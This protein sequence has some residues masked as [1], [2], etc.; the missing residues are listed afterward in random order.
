M[1]ERK[2]DIFIV[3]FVASILI[4]SL[5]PYQAL[6]QNENSEF[7]PGRYIIVLEDDISP[8]EVIVSKGK[9]PDFVFN[10]A[11]NGFA[12]SFSAKFLEDMEKDPRVKFIEKDQR[13]HAFL[14]TTP[15]GID[16]IDAEGQVSVENAEVVVAVLDT[17]IDDTHPDLNVIKKVNCAKGGPFGGNCVE[18]DGNDG[19]GHGTHVAGT[20]GAIQNDIGVEGVAPGVKIVAVKVLDNKG[21]GWTSWIIGGIDY[22]TSTRTN[23]DPN[24][25]IDV[26]NMSLG[27]GNSE[28]EKTAIQNS[29]AQGIVYVVAAGN[30]GIEA[31]NTSPANTPE[32][33]TVSALADS[34]GICGSQ[35]DPT[36]Y[37]PD[38]TFA[39][40]SNFGSFVDIAAPGTDIYSTLPGGY[41]FSSGTSMASPHVAGAVALYIIDNGKPTNA[42]GVETLRNQLVS[43][44]ISQTENCLDETGY[45]GFSGDLDNF[46]EPLLYVGL[47]DQDGD[48]VLDPN[49]NCPTIANTNQADNYGTT[50]GDACEDTD[51][52]TV[53]DDTDNC[54]I[55]SNVNQ[56]DL[57][58]DLLG[59]LCDLVNMITVNTILTNDTTLKGDLIVESEIL[60]TINNGV[61]MDFDFINQKLQIKSGGG[62]LILSG[63]T[64]T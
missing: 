31:D 29:V 5:T 26:V 15:T 53:L 24:D 43:S 9:I 57:D 61:T 51:S 46:P 48:G 36:S 28:S 22:V 32:V 44:G 8:L 64:I 52:D 45:G 38:D 42:A 33:I 37:G 3:F 2:K 12:G 34:D 60:F 41:G 13:V 20:I 30:E 25:D 16:R 50:A 40:F 49:D 58:S 7:T 6:G 17:G 63:G 56:N 47:I 54:P 1:M 21:S 39:T 35:G 10:H 55:V 19:H 62:I 23:S 59:D 27:G 4:F 18:N 14:Q 11:I